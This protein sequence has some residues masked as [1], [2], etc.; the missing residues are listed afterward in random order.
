MSCIAGIR[1][2]GKVFLGADS[3]GVNGWQITIR[4]DQKVFI[5]GEYLMGFTGSFRLGQLL[6]YKLQLPKPPETASKLY[7]F[8]VNEFVDATRACLKTC[9]VATKENEAERGGTFL[10]GV[11]GRLFLIEADYQV[12]ETADAFIAVGCGA[13]YALGSLATS[14]GSPP[15][16]IKRA[17]LTA[18]H[19]CMG[20]RGPFRVLTAPG[21]SGESVR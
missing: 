14:S 13:P 1:Q 8:M 3:A 15:A 5:S 11:R 19:F 6:Q 17:L 18:Q 7:P 2:A 4:A 16:R 21:G 10:V 12:A 20:V 9:G